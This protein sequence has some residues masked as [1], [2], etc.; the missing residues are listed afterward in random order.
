M[1]SMK[2]FKLMKSLTKLKTSK[3]YLTYKILQKEKIRE[4][5]RAILINKHPL[6]M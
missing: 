1:M 4:C 3:I 2:K 6:F 5:K